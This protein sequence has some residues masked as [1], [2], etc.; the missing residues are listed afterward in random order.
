MSFNIF[1]FGKLF[2]SKLRQF[3]IQLTVIA[4][5]Q[6]S[7]LQLVQFSSLGVTAVGFGSHVVSS[8]DLTDYI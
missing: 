5:I 3:E 7:S 2:P 8:C 6:I 4:V 1:L